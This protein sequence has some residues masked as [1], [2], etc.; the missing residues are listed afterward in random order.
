M[1]NW[2][3]NHRFGRLILLHWFFFLFFRVSFSVSLQSV[4]HRETLWKSNAKI[5]G[6]L[7]TVSTCFTH[8]YFYRCNRRKKKI[9]K[10][11][12][13]L[14]SV[15][16][17]LLRWGS[18]SIDFSF[19]CLLNDMKFNCVFKSLVKCFH[20]SKFQFDVQNGLFQWHRSTDQLRVLDWNLFTICS[21]NLCGHQNHTIAQWPWQTDSFN[22][23]FDPRPSTR[24]TVA[25]IKTESEM[26]LF[27][28]LFSW[29]SRFE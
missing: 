27:H 21:L 2:L 11:S 26:I 25:T 18:V 12:I 6:Q 20:F 17:F 29:H 14:I 16:L 23:W 10:Y 22:R 8:L 9:C 3:L 5:N 19:T 24:A 13:V 15:I 4:F 7:T 1:E 28:R